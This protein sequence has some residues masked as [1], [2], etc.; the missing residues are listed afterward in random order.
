MSPSPQDDNDGDTSSAPLLGRAF[1][2][3]NLRERSPSP[4]RMAEGPSAADDDD[5]RGESEHGASY[6]SP[7]ATSQLLSEFE[8]AEEHLEFEQWQGLAVGVCLV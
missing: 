5:R 8:R 7:R 1:S 3:N 6:F 2:Y 4:Q